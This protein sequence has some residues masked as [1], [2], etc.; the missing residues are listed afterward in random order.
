MGLPLL[1]MIL[2]GRD[3]FSG[4]VWNRCHDFSQ[5]RGTLVEEELLQPCGKA[6]L[7][8]DKPRPSGRIQG[9]SMYKA[10]SL[11]TAGSLQI[12][13]QGSTSRPRQEREGEERRGETL[14]QLGRHSYLLH[15]L[16][17]VEYPSDLRIRA[18]KR[19]NTLRYTLLLNTSQTIGIRARKSS[20]TL[21]CTFS[22]STPL[23]H[24]DS[25][26][27]TIEHPMG[28]TLAKH[29]LDH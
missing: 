24:Q 5:N 26:K 19:S 1:P 13:L 8:M 16:A 18:R 23:D 9:I 22:P 7:P 11:L 21:R 20:N 4:N 15:S 14:D 2:Y 12:Q 28:Y 29:P 3:P 17:L 25:S 10:R 6:V 27:E